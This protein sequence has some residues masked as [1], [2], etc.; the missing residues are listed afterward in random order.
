[1]IKTPVVF[2]HNSTVIKYPTN[3]SQWKNT[4][5]A[6]GFLVGTYEGS[7][8][9]ADGSTKSFPWEPYMPPAPFYGMLITSLAFFDRLFEVE[10]RF[11]REAAKVNVDVQRLLSRAE[12]LT[13]EIDLTRADVITGVG[14]VLLAM[15]AAGI[16]GY[17]LDYIALRKSAILETPAAWNELPAKLKANL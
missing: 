7:L 2:E 9:L 15:V 17:T 11:F 5:V 16:D 3:R 10:E 14:D 6:N 13:D 4:F 8:F 12:L 1:M